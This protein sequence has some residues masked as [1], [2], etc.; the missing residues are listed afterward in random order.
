MRA[1]ALRGIPILLVVAAFHAES[2]SRDE[3]WR[4][5][6]MLHA[7]SWL[8]IE[9]SERLRYEYLDNT[10][11]VLDP[12]ADD[13]LVS[14]LRL[15]VRADG[16]HLY[17]GIEF[18][19]SRGWFDEPFTPVGTDDVNVLEPLQ[20]YLGYRGSSLFAE[21]DGLDLQVGRFTLDVGSRRLLA[22]NR[23]RNTTS[24]FT[25]L[26]LTWT[27][28]GQVV[29]RSFLT[30]PSTRLPNTLEPE[31][32]RSNEF[33]LD[34]DQ[35]DHV[36]WG[37]HVSGVTLPLSIDSEWYLYGL[38]E[39]DRPGVPTRNRDLATAGLR[40]QKNSARWAGEVEV[41]Y[42]FGETRATAA[43]A[44]L[45]DLDHRA[46]FAHAELTRQ[47][48]GR[49]QPRIIFRYDYAS[50][51]RDP[52]DGRFERF[53]TLFGD[54]R[55]EFG[56]TGIYGALTRSNIQSPG[57]ALRLRPASD[58][59]LRLDYRAAWL[60]SKKDAMPTAGLWDPGGN[61]G[62]FIGQQVDARVNWQVVQDSLAV[63]LGAAY[64]FKGEFLRD[65]PNAPPSSD[66]VYLYLASTL[67]F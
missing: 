23:F 59:D 11:R 34:Q 26:S 67:T 36:F 12:G 33:E 25:G 35:P 61:S 32:L 3:P 27:S 30:M 54:R 19:D 65:A 20:A 18:Q 51:D 15:H 17:G 5:G 64:L 50:G 31:R 66:T 28:P 43:P 24:S 55:W 63:E 21:G 53:D 56:P 40:L 8:T 14:R 47:Y 2:A 13:Y 10:F 1:R 4:L 39:D 48:A 44:D 60:A 7:P 22:R 57:V 42:Q 41:A 52:G 49:W 16:R 9:G 29:L 62:A 6:E 46:W 38:R 37:L 45:A 58:L